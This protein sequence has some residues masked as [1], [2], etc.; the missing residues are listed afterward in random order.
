MTEPRPHP[1]LD[2]IAQLQ[3]D[4]VT[5]RDWAALLDDALQDFA[6]SLNESL[7]ADTLRDADHDVHAWPTERGALALRA[8]RERKAAGLTR[9]QLSRLTHVADSTIRNVERGRH[10]ASKHTLQRLLPPLQQLERTLHEL[11]ATTPPPDGDHRHVRIPPR[12]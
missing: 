3:H 12:P 8:R 10:N 11:R 5:L 2:Q 1:L 9:A 6:T 4:V 7:A